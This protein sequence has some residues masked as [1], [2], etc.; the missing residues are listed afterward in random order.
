MPVLLEKQSCKAGSVPRWPR[1]T[2]T[3]SQTSRAPPDAAQQVQRCAIRVVL[4]LTFCGGTVTAAS[5]TS[6]GPQSRHLS[7]MSCV[8]STG[9][10]FHKPLAVV[11]TSL[12]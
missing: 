5:P 10:D 1:H 3:S 2:V 4:S 8:P 6:P 9:C 12:S 11:P 7:G